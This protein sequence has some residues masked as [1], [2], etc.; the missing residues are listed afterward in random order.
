MNRLIVI[1]ALYF[2]FVGCNSGSHPTSDY[3]VSDKMSALQTNGS[4]EAQVELAEPEDGTSIPAHQRKIIKEGYISFESGN[5]TDTRAH[6]DSILNLTSGF[7]SSER[8]FTTPD[9]ISQ[10]LSVR[11]PIGRF[12]EFVERLSRG[13]DRFDDK[14][15][16][17]SD[18]TAEY[19]DIAARIKTKKELEQRYLALLSQANSVTEILEIE[20]ELGDIRGEIESVEGR[21]RYLTDQTDY[22]TLTITYYKTVSAPTAFGGQFSRGFVN[23]WNNL[24]W[25]LV[26]LV[27]VWPFVILIPTVVFVTTRWWVRRRDTRRNSSR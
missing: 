24:I 16:S 3:A 2:V 22:S 26:G 1:I 9:R 8:E 23:G 11:V 4:L 18:V 6:I 20:K 14:S 15:I 5:L 27:N 7:V 12:D 19:I 21:L 25:F 10:S 17:S 13:V